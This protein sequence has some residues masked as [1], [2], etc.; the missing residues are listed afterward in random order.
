MNAN[1]ESF[2]HRATSNPLVDAA[3]LPRDATVYRVVTCYQCCVVRRRCLNLT[4]F[5]LDLSRETQPDQVESDK[6]LAWRRQA[7]EK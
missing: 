2:E 7:P 3:M 1:L 5:F 6:Q 4:Q